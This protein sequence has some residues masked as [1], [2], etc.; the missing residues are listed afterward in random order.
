[1]KTILILS[2]HRNGRPAWRHRCKASLLL[3]YDGER[4]KVLEKNNPSKLLPRSKPTTKNMLIDAKD[5]E[6]Y[7]T[8]ENQWITN[9]FGDLHL[10]L[11]PEHDD[12]SESTENQGK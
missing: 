11:F 6:Y 1:M 8:E 9:T 12:Q 5:W 10:N 3:V 4:W 2:Y 7:D